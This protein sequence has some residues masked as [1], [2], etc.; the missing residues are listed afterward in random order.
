M[1]NKNI[2]ALL[3][4]G[5][6]VV[7]GCGGQEL[8]PDLPKLYPATIL[9]ES[10]EGP[11]ADATVVLSPEQGKWSAMGTTGENGVVVLKT[12]GTYP[13]AAEGRY[14]VLISK[15]SV[16]PIDPSK[17]LTGDNTKV[18]YEIDPS[19]NDPQKSSLKMDI[20]SSENNVTF[21]VHKPSN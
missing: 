9:V 7:F 5:G 4:L 19:F 14:Q 1:N 15:M 10:D 2:V 16:E 21:Q 18:T 20:A 13:G 6:L 11:V 3:F 8:P 17:K 12:N